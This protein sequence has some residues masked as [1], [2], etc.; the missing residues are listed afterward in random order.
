MGLAKT[1]GKLAFEEHK[2]TQT[3]TH[4]TVAVHNPSESCKKYIVMGKSYVLKRS[5]AK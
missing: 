1:L 2:V 5:E 4:W 3:L